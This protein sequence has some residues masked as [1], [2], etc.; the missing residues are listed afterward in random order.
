MKKQVLLLSVLLCWTWTQAQ[1]LYVRLPLESPASQVMQRVGL[2][3]VNVVYHSP[4][5]K[6]RVIWGDLVPYNEVWRAGANENTT[7]SFS[8]DVEVNGKRLP[9]GI[10]GLHMI[11]GETEWV[12]IFSNNSSSWGSFFYRPAEDALR[13]TVQPETIPIC[14]S[15]TYDFHNRTA[16]STGVQMRWE[17]KAVS[18][19]VRI[20]PMQTVIP[21]IR[22]QLRS[23]ASFTWQGW[24]DAADY[25]LQNNINL[26]E[27]LYWIDESI[28]ADENFSN[29]IIKAQLLEKTG[30]QADARKAFVKAME[31]GSERELNRYGYRLLR[32]N[33]IN[34]AIEVFTINV[35]H[36]PLSWD[37]LDSLG[38]AYAQA[39]QTKNAIDTYRK[40]LRMA[41]EDEKKHISSMLRELE[42]KTK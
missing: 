34:E 22:N 23:S 15:L 35:R 26:E 29:T 13:L 17:K 11:P 10:Y 6:G 18:F 16:T 40:A 37:A 39:G 28:D 20:D 27:A 21:D 3:D 33:R 38:D 5:V 42:Q 24:R 19:T 32:A 4:S 31:L 36:Y 12:I 7:I 14:E 1:S 8:T 25:C 9:R 2:T 30:K 41:P